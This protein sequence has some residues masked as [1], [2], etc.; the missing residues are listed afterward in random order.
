MGRISPTHIVTTP[1]ATPKGVRHSSA[2]M[3]RPLPQ[4]HPA[5]R[6]SASGHVT[7]QPRAR[8]LP[9]QRSDTAVDRRTLPARCSGARRRSDRGAAGS[10]W[11]PGTP[12]ARPRGR[13]TSWTS[14]R[15]ARSRRRR[16]HQS[17]HARLAGGSPTAQGSVYRPCQAIA[18]GL[19]ARRP[20]PTIGTTSNAATVASQSAAAVRPSAGRHATTQ[21]DPDSQTPH[22]GDPRPQ[23]HVAVSRG[24]TDEA[25]RA[26]RG[27][28]VRPRSIPD[29]A[30]RRRRRRGDD[31]PS[32]T[33]TPE[34][35]ELHRDV[36]DRDRTERDAARRASRQSGPTG[37]PLTRTI[38]TIT[39]ATSATADAV[40]AEQHAGH[41]RHAPP[42]AT[43][44][45]PARRARRED[46]RPQAARGGDLHAARVD[47]AGAGTS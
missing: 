34:R 6:R 42:A 2:R 24:R 18:D 10:G 4:G 5:D 26:S 37:V 9:S 44:A 31:A 36:S 38:A 29:D 32:T 41:R 28:A 13:G 23:R 17:P 15:R 16:P 39:T 19:A 3:P 45:P 25:G 33:P 11:R 43:P 7:E 47:G 21:E 22:R 35:D 40:D 46:R 12:R 1:R 20:A 30:P 8:D 27:S 14:R